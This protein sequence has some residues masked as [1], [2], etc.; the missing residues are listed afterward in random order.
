M[1]DVAGSN[2]A[3]RDTLKQSVDPRVARTRAGIA[4]A[5]HELSE[6]GEELSVASI[7]RVAGISRASFYS[8][9]SGVDELADSL[10]RDAFLTIGDLFLSDHD[11]ERPEA[12]R[13]SQERLVAHFADNRA[14][15]NAV[16]AIPVSKDGYL[17]GV[18]AMAG[19]IEIALDEHP[20]RPR[21]LQKEAVARYIAGAAYGLLDAWIAGELELTESEV[22]DHLTRLL[23]PWFSGVR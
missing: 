3:I 7:V 5:V 9:Y 2:K 14:L 18:R 10:R 16:G 20:D 23:P 22:V 19:V 21:D 12:M 1:S 13:L 15:Y 17:V 6:V 8:H 11:H 4:A